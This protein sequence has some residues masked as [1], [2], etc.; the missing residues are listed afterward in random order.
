M[1]KIKQLI[2]RL[3]RASLACHFQICPFKYFEI[4]SGAKGKMG[5]ELQ[6]AG[7]GG[8]STVAIVGV[9]DVQ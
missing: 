5:F 4:A 1:I 8:Q 6:A 7:A 3:C 2:I 9:G